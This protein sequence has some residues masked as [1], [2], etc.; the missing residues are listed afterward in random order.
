MSDNLN[1]NIDV[2]RRRADP[3]IVAMN[4]IHQYGEDGFFKLIELLKAGESGTKIGYIFNVT[5]Q[6]VCQ[7][8]K[9]LL[10][11]R[12]QWFI[13]PEIAHLFEK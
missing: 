12:R 13:K 6:R 5:R 9:V 10:T 11:E 1:D 7:W 4:L 3:R 8:R 2:T